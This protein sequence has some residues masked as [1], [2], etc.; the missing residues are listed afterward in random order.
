MFL[1]IDWDHALVHQ[2][3]SCP[4]K[5]FANWY[6]V[7]TSAQLNPLFPVQLLLKKSW[8]MPPVLPSDSECVLL[9]RRLHTLVASTNVA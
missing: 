7:H 3:W 2:I 9:W 1:L 6:S 4:F 5:I 8:H